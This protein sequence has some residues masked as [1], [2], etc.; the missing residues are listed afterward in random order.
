LTTYVKEMP[1][2]E[3]KNVACVKVNP[4]DEKCDDEPMRKPILRIKKYILD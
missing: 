1:D 2:K 3:Y 4:D